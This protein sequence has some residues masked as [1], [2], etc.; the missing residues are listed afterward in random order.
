[1]FIVAFP[2]QRWLRERA[3]IVRVRCLSFYNRRG[4]KIGRGA[5]GLH[6]PNISSFFT[7]RFPSHFSFMFRLTLPFHHFSFTLLI[8]FFRFFQIFVL[9]LYSGTFTVQSRS[10]TD[11]SDEPVACRNS[12]GNVQNELKRRFSKFYVLLTAHL[13]TIF[14]NKP[15]WFTIFS[16]MFIYILYMFRGATAVAQW[17]RC[18]ATNLKVAGSIPDVVIGIFH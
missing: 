13:I 7:L 2:L 4:R 11:V 5:I 15:T 17:L 10:C 1:M 9:Y 18:C 12:R 16:Y 14:V 8:L 3:S 6:F